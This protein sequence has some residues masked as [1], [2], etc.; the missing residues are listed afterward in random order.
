LG[1]YFFGA[2]LQLALVFVFLV[3][4]STTAAVKTQSVRAKQSASF[5]LE[6][7]GGFLAGG[8][9]KNA[10]VEVGEGCCWWLE[11]PTDY[12]KDQN[13]EREGSDDHEEHIWGRR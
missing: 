5:S 8:A 6:Q 13:P 9:Q 4:S 11:V 10:S 3:F 7:A 1:G 12:P 2:A